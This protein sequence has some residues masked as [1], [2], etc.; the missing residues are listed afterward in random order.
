MI[1]V[2]IVLV[3]KFRPQGILPPQRELIWPDAIAGSETKPERHTNQ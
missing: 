3:M 2:L 1:G